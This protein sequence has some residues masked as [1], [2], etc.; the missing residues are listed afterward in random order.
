M[1]SYQKTNVVTGSIQ[2][3]TKV[4]YTAKTH[5]LGGRRGGVSRSDDG[6]LDVKFSAPGVP[7]TGTNPEQLFAAGWSACFI[8]TMGLVASRMKIKLPADV[9]IDAEIDLCNSGDVYFLR[10]RLNVSLPGLDREVA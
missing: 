1:T 9:A 7:G 5:T 2:E 10:A 8:S 3:E 4:K 6:R